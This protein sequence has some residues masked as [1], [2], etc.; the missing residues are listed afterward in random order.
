M[1]LAI[2]NFSIRPG[3]TKALKYEW[4]SVDTVTKVKTPI[5]LTG[6]DA[7]MQIRTREGDPSVLIE[8]SVTNGRISMTANG[9][10]L[11]T[12]P[13]GITTGYS[14]K[15]AVYDILLTYNGVITEFA[16]GVVSLDTG[17]TT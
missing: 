3:A 17:V 7:K 9:E 6:Y 12:I 15:R 13:A 14:A 4:Y 1:A 2:K 11:V 5:N 8:C 10:I 16:S